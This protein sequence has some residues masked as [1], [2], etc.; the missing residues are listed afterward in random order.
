MGTTAWWA[1]LAGGGRHPGPTPRADLLLV[2]NV[3]FHFVKLFSKQSAGFE[4]KYT[5]VS[6]SAGRADTSYTAARDIPQ[7]QIQRE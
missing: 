4:V 6:S 2:L 5:L 1:A 3:T 7:R